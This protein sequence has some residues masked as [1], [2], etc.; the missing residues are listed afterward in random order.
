MKLKISQIVTMQQ[1]IQKLMQENMPIKA[2]YRLS[3]IANIID[4]EMQ[5]IEQKRAELVKKYGED[6]GEGNYKVK[7]E[8]LTIFYN[9]YQN[10][11][12]EEVDLNISPIQI[13]MLENTKMSPAAINALEPILDLGAWNSNNND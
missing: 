1:P 5:T 7:P 10:L 4:Q 12:D 2:A 3:R 6:N 8:N 11:L 9:E 13:E